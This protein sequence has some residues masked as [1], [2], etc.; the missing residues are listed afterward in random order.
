LPRLRKLVDAAKDADA[1]AAVWKD[2][3]AEVR[4]TKDMG[5]YNAFKAAVAARGSVLRGEAMP[6]DT[7]PDDGKTID[8][9]QRDPSDDGFGRD[10]QGGNQE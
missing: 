6:T 2:G 1:L 7:P 5:I 10:D 3:L 9:P 8:E 4:A